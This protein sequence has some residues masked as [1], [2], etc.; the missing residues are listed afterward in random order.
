MNHTKPAPQ[1]FKDLRGAA[2]GEVAVR[3]ASACLASSSRSAATACRAWPCSRHCG[4][5]EMAFL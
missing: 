2:L 5:P 4:A 1:P 3:K